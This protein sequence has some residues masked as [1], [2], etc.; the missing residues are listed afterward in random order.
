MQLGFV[1]ESK[2][3][4]G[5][6]ACTVACKDKHN[7]D[8]GQNYRRVTEIEGGS[9][10]KRGDGYVNTVYSYNVS[11]SCNHCEDP[12][13]VKNCPSG[14]MKKDP[15]TG[16]VAIDENICIGCGYCSW[17]CP[18]NAPQL[19]K[20]KGV[21]EKCDFCKEA[22]EKGEEPACVAACPLRLLHYGDIEKLRKDYPVEGKVK[23]MPDDAVTKPS[24]VIVPHK[25][26]V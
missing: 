19:N 20:K 2:Y 3:C 22:Q 23:I 8:V 25:D 6:K 10:A 12:K 13:C 1:H 18:Y 4:T 15:K 17:S 11:I 16:I 24:L 9:F 21:M 7:S 26:S 5:C 14:A